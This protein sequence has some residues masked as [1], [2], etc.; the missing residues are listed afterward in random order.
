MERV[1]FQPGFGMSTTQQSCQIL[2][3]TRT[4]SLHYWKI[5][6]EVGVRWGRGWYLADTSH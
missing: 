3:E 5:A 4:S 6:K 2:G 1:A